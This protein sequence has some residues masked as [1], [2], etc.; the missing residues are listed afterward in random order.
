MKTATITQVKKFKLEFE[1]FDDWV[2]IKCN[3]RK[4][5]FLLPRKFFDKMEAKY[6]KGK[7]KYNWLLKIKWTDIYVALSKDYLKQYFETGDWGLKD[8]TW[9]VDALP[10]LRKGVKDRYYQADVVT[11]GFLHFDNKPV[12]RPFP[13]ELR[14]YYPKSEVVEKLRKN[15]KVLSVKLKEIPCYNQEP[16]RETAY[17]YIVYMPSVK[18][19]NGFVVKNKIS[20]CEAQW[21]I[22][23]RLGIKRFKRKD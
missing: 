11:D 6:T 23:L 16:G 5:P 14:E 3:D 12:R 18:E 1:K 20:I 17:I 8:S 9:I 4:D 22:E 10:L 15:S 19:F 13:I 7:V 2:Y 21:D